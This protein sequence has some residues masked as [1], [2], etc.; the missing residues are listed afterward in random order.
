[1]NFIT[2]TA[3]T[4]DL[5]QIQEIIDMHEWQIDPQEYLERLGL[6][7][8]Q[9]KRELHLPRVED[10]RKIIPLRDVHTILS[11]I[12]INL[13]LLKYLIRRINTLDGQ[14]PFK[15]A[16]VQIV[17]IDPRHLKIGQQFVYRE[18]Y[19]K[20]LEEVPDI[21]GKFVVN[22]GGLGD[23][24]GYFVF[25]YNGSD[26]YSLA[27][28]VPPI[29]ERHQSEL[30]VMDGIHRN[31]IA[32]QSGMAINAILVNNVSLPFP[33][34]PRDWSDIKVIPLAEKPKD[35][36]ERYFDLKKE[37]FRDLKYLGIDG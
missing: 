15:V 30:I 21:F 31:Y 9:F 7:L 4:I 36:N 19:Q 10:V 14:S 8:G 23:L 34:G 16:E 6:N 5:L 11:L 26:T 12:P 3:T 20:L 28:Y 27:C 2:Y 33:C 24:G 18:N 37:L 35:I 22:P 25:G 13:E 1:L 32:K 17:K 29:I